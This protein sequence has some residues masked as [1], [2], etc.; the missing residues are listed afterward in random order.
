MA[1]RKDHTHEE[2]RT[3]AVG[4][5]MEHLQSFPPETLSLRKVAQRV[6]YSPATLIN[7]FGSYDQLLLAAN[8]QTLDQ[9]SARLNNA[10]TRHPGGLEQLLA[11]A[12]AYLEFAHQHRYQWQLLFQHRMPDGETVP[13]WQQQRI[14]SLFAA[15]ENAL[16][17]LAPAAPEAELQLASRTI[18]ASV[19]GIC[20][21]ALDDKLFAGSHIHG[22]PMMSSLIRHYVS[23][24]CQQHNAPGATNNKGN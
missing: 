10:Q 6:G 8:A 1:R 2:I 7:V 17:Q 4:I 5:L 12:E 16:S 23:A 20:A 9:L 21:L 14:D 11:F 19:H 22:T 3:L 18:W 24:W 15:I 13:H